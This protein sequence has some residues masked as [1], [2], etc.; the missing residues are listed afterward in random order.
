MS[1]DWL[2]ESEPNCSVV[3]FEEA[4]GFP[5]P[6]HPAESSVFA[7][8]EGVPGHNQ[9]QLEAAR[10][11]IAGA[12][13]L[14]SWT[15]LALARSGVRHITL[16]DH[17]VFE[18]TNA[19]RQLMFPNDLGRPKSFAVAANLRSHMM[20][21]G[22]VIG[23][24]L[25][26]AEAVEQYATSADLVVALVDNNACR[27]HASRYARQRGVPAIFSML[28]TDSMRAHTFLQGT[29]IADACLWCALPNLDAAAVAPCGSATIASCFMSAA[30][31]TFFAFRALMGWPAGADEFNWRATDLMGCTPEEIS[32]ITKRDNCALCGSA[33]DLDLN[34][35]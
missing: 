27:L 8:H 2:S 20:A 12:G 16:I 26:F 21:S 18:R 15:A 6:T 1:T 23:M 28:S 19:P 33:S 7:R 35:L 22:E 31:S 32:L 17:D 14:G 9:E 4:A 13:G 29:E 11:V 24:D 5:A 3:S 10:V 30:H 34:P 25:P